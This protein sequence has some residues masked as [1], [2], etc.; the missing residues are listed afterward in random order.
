[1]ST[2]NDL[3]RYIILL[4]RVHPSP[5]SVLLGSVPPPSGAELAVLG[6]K[7]EPG[8]AV[9]GGKHTP[10]AAV[11]AELAE[12]VVGWAHLT[13]ACKMYRDAYP[14]MWDML[15]EYTAVVHGSSSRLDVPQLDRLA[16]KYG[17]SR[18]TLWRNV[19]RFPYELAKIALKTKC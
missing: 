16:E 3:A 9:Q 11:C 2:K 5:F 8:M 17:A 7:P 13:E 14:T 12:P 15:V 4:L 18:T 1:M 6:N 19:R 10:D